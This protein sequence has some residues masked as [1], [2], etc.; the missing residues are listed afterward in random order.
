MQVI[1]NAKEPKKPI[2]PNIKVNVAIGIIL[3][4]VLGGIIAFIKGFKG[5]CINT[6][7]DV[8]GNLGIPVLG[9]IPKNYEDTDVFEVDKN[10]RSAI[11]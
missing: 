9:V 7:E 11:S 6:K 8:E 4:G 1:R 10:P 3:G 2:S 5:S